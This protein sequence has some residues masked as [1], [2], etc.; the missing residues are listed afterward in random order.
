MF[1]A[2]EPQQQPDVDIA[3]ASVSLRNEK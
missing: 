2:H 3:H 1:A